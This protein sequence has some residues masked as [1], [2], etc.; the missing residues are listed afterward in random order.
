MTIYLRRSPQNIMSRLTEY[1]R[2]KRPMFRGKSDEELLQ[3]MTSH[4]AERE[5]HYLKAQLVVECDTM[6]D[7][8]AVEYI[9]NS[10]K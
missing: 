3:F 6:S 1:G 7:D 4:M 10:I 5:P 2:E 8:A 9:A